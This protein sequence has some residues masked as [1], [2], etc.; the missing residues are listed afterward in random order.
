MDEVLERALTRQ[1]ELVEWDETKEKVADTPVE[2]ESS[3]LTAH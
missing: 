3:Q 1:P 2:E